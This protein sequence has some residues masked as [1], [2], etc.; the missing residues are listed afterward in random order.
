VLYEIWSIN[1]PLGDVEYYWRPYLLSNFCR[2]SAVIRYGYYFIYD[3]GDVRW[4]TS[5]QSVFVSVSSYLSQCCTAALRVLC[6]GRLRRRMLL[7][8]R[9]RRK[10]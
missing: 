7:S 5:V 8:A 1:H 4:W 9:H 10:W 3:S 2:L 6:H